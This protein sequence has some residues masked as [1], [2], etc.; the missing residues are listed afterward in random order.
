MQ[1]SFSELL[2]LAPEMFVLTMACV[3]LVV[4]AFFGQQ[5]PQLSYMLTQLTLLVAAVISGS[6]LDT[7]TRT[8]LR[9]H[10]RAR[11]DG[12]PA[13]DQHLPGRRRAPSSMRAATSRPSAACAASITCWACSRCWA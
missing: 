12:G 3:I 4:E 9:R 2:I 5:R 11:P 6:M 1:F 8:G 7:G 10:L 13:E